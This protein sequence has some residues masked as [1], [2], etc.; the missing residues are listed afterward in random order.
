MTTIWLRDEDKAFEKRTPLTPEN[1]KKLLDAG[2]EIIVEEAKDRIFPISEYEAVGCKIVPSHSWITDAPVN[3]DTF[4]LGLKELKE[5]DTFP[6]KRNHIYFA[7][8]Y[9]GQ[10]GAEQVFNRYREG[11]GTLFDLEFLVNE[12]KRRVAAF[13]YWAGYVGAALSVENFFSDKPAPL[14]HYSSKNEWLEVINKK[15]QGKRNPCTFI[16]GALGRCG[17]GARE[18]LS[19]LELESINWDVQ[20][21]QVGGPFSEIINADIFINTVLMTKKIS[22]FL[23]K[24]LMEKNQHLS[25]I[26]DV[27]CDPNSDLNPIPIYDIH[28]TWDKPLHKIESSLDHE[29]NII[30]IDNL[31]SALPR[32]SSIDY[33]D[34][35]IAHLLEL[36]NAK[37]YYTWKH[38]KEIFE[39]KKSTNN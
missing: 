11:G 36:K 19:D 27:S 26:C 6:L 24:S 15:R 16:I 25:Y 18:L 39:E 20:E 14:K 29:C 34:Q 10:H 12:D 31:P 8:I 32:E 37:N 3:D 23:D 22:P 9:K 2:F 38:A 28:T 13:G 7:H 30:A 17:S 33:S 21:T 5:E 1:A 35:L 4:I